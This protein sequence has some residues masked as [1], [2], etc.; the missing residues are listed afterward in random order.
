MKHFDTVIFDLDGTLLD[1]LD[2]LTDSVNYVLQFYGYPVRTR[3]EV[4]QFVGN[5]VRLLMERALPQGKENPQFDSCLKLFY[6]YYEAHRQDRTA[7]YSG[8]LPLLQELHARGIQVG[9]VSNKF[10]AAV[11]ALSQDYFLGLVDIAIGESPDVRKKPAPDSVLAALQ[12]LHADA[13]QAVYVGDS[14]VDVETAHNSGMPC[15]GVSW[16]FRGREFLTAC[17]ADA[18]IDRPEE[19]LKILEVGLSN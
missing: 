2:D 5:G 19:L 8:I 18:I 11:K 1:T 7:P 15:V 14:D 17:G 6:E 12:Q 16:G 3:S 4:Q 10:D 9:I 13:S